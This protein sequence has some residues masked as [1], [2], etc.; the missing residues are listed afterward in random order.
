MIVL[1][2]LDVF[3]VVIGTP[4]AI[5]LGAPAFGCLMGAAAWIVQRVIYYFD[6]RYTAKLSEPRKQL[7][8]NL[9]EAFGRIWLLGGAIII[10]GVAGGRADGL[11]AA[12]TIFAAYSVGLVVRILSGPPQQSGPPRQSGPPPRSAT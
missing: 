8:F 10:A 2:F 12:L 11:A 3:V 4:V 6:R 7:G 1:T 9:F 5:A